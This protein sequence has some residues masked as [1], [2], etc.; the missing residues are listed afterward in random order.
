MST[1]H[2]GEG[3]VE[4]QSQKPLISTTIWHLILNTLCNTNDDALRVT[5]PAYEA[6]KTEETFQ[7]E[8]NLRNN[9]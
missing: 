1:L 5:I 7:V 3:D 9:C 8:D 4:V 2:N 6:L